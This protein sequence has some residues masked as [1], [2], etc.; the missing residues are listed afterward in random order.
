MGRYFYVPEAI[1]FEE[2]VDFR[3]MIHRL[4][5]DSSPYAPPFQ[6]PSRWVWGL[7]APQE[8]LS[9][10]SFLYQQSALQIPEVP[11]NYEVS[12][13]RSLAQRYLYI[14]LTLLFVCCI[15]WRA[16]F[17]RLWA[18][19]TVIPFLVGLYGSLTMLEL[20]ARFYLN[21]LPATAL[22]IAVSSSLLGKHSQSWLYCGITY[23]FWLLL[24]LGVL[25]SPLS[26]T[27]SWQHRF[28]ASDPTFPNTM[29]RY[30]SGEMAQKS[31]LRH[32]YRA[33]QSLELDEQ[34]HRVLIFQ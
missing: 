16:Q 7:V 6:Y 8:M 29:R 19:L 27:S 18:L 11:I 9:T 32:C 28:S 24:I 2:Q 20:H 26:P 31:D 34:P 17:W 25:S 21:T 33:L 3:P 4:L 5:G 10:L 22:L 14:S 1:G 13:A 12:I 23:L 30:Y 15:T